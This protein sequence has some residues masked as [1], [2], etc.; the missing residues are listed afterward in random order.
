MQKVIITTGMT[1]SGKSTWAKEFVKE[2]QE[3]TRFC[4]DDVR[5]MLNGGD[6]WIHFGAEKHHMNFIENT[7]TKM[8]D[9]AIVK[10]LSEGKS[11]VLDETNARS[12]TFNEICKMLKK[13]DFDVTV[14][15]KMFYI[16]LD[17]A[18]ARDRA[19]TPKVGDEVM[20]Q[21]WIK[22]EGKKFADYK[23]KSA[24]FTKLP[25][26]PINVLTQAKNAIICD[27]DGCL[28]LFGEN[29]PYHRDFTQDSPNW[30]VVNIL[31]AFEPTHEIIFVSGRL[32][33]YREQTKKWLTQWGFG[34]KMLLMRI[35][36]D[37]RNDARVKWEFYRDHIH[38]KYNVNFVLD[39]RNRVVNMWRNQ[40][41]TCLQVAE[42]DF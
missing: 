26:L 19:R 7:V 38:D 18:L 27:L 6:P 22:F 5:A 13:H 29:N 35:E 41:L 4:R 23:P 28:A 17:T 10:A 31:K 40:G 12:R 32:N 1:A 9:Q 37:W 33:D 21:M 30:P 25:V 39:D 14:E 11:I 24:V 16:D 2:N 3:Y 34:D 42:G 36:D 20:A 15:E 8:R